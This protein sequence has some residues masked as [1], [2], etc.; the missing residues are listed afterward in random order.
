MEGSTPR[1]SDR[2]RRNETAITAVLLTC[3]CLGSAALGWLFAVVTIYRG[4]YI[5]AGMRM[6]MLVDV[7]GRYPWALIVA[8]VLIQV[9]VAL[10]AWR[11]RRASFWLAIE[12][13]TLAGLIFVLVFILP[14]NV[15]GP[16]HDLDSVLR[17]G[18]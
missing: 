18:R 5:A 11:S 16:I 6:P 15:Y 3:L 8:A 2:S 4:I 14:G 9:A 10:L 7:G 17:N 12:V 1:M 13:L